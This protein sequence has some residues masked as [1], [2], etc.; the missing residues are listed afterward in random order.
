MNILLLVIAI[1]L[2]FL[3]MLGIRTMQKDHLFAIAHRAE[4]G[5]WVM[6]AAYL[7]SIEFFSVGTDLMQGP[8]LNVEISLMLQLIILMIM[9]TRIF[10]CI[11]FTLGNP[12]KVRIE[13]NP[14]DD[15]VSLQPTTDTPSVKLDSEGHGQV[16][17]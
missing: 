13:V 7:C 5:I 11:A 17:L 10:S 8:E 9:V 16:L 12:P 14:Q 4:M 1:G 15:S 3:Q 2:I 6:F